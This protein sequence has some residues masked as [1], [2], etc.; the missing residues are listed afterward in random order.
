MWK[1]GWAMRAETH[2]KKKSRFVP[3]ERWH[4]GQATGAPF[5]RAFLL[6]KKASSFFSALLDFAREKN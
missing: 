6:K 2:E 5:Q 1:G 4:E 3:N